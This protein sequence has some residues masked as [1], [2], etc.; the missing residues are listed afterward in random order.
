MFDS[1]QPP[2]NPL[3]PVMPQPGMTSP[4]PTDAPTAPPPPPTGPQ[5]FSMPEKFRAS[6]SGPSKSS[7]TKKLVIILIVVAVVGA[8]G[9]GGL[10]LFQ[11]VLNKSNT[12]AAN[13]NV[14]ENVNTVA[15]LNDNGNANVDTNAATNVNSNSN[16]TV[17][18]N[19]NGNV[20]SA[21]NGNAN[22]NANVAVNTNANTNAATNSNTNAAT[23]AA[24]PL[25]S[26]TDAD[27]DGLTDV[28]EKVYGT[29]PNKPDTDGDGFIDGK[30][31]RPDGTIAGELYLGY[32]PLGAGRLEGSAIVKRALNANKEYSVLIPAKWASTTD[33]SGGILINPDVSTG[34]FFQVRKVDNAAKLTPKQ[35]YQANN[36]TANVDALTTFAVN[37]LEVLYSEDASTAYIFKDATVY[38]FTYS[39]GSLTQVNYRTTFDMMVRNF[40]LE[41]ATTK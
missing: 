12:N 3:N 32:N 9:V 10:Y 23:V 22:S 39:T 33:A 19:T 2:Q 30:Q 21:I 8:L 27:S 37:G 24:S 18:G 17:N 13:T 11:N 36:P 38:T 6:G 41:S 14:S 16:A 34:E 25:P 4:M 20:N 5:V 7:G 29:D 1:P 31:V 28:E 26:S 15:N 35:W 40:K